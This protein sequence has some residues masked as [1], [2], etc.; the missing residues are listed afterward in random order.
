MIKRQYNNDIFTIDGYTITVER[1]GY[2]AAGKNRYRVGIIDDN[3]HY[4]HEI[5]YTTTSYESEAG[6]ATRVMNYYKST[7]KA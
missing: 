1:R 7:L 6:E 2:T 4:P 3:R 5:V